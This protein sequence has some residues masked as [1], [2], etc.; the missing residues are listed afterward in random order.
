MRARRMRG[1]SQRGSPA[2]KGA[3]DRGE[4]VKFTPWIQALNV[5]LASL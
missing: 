4:C 3:L 2:V 1:C 5:G